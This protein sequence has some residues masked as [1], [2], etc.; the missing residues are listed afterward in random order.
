MRKRFLPLLALVALA[1]CT[2]NDMDLKESND[3]VPIMAGANALSVD[4]STVTRAPFEETIGADNNLT[5]MVLTSKTS[6]SYVQTYAKGCM[7]FADETT[8]VGYITDN[9]TT[10]P[11]AVAFSGDSYYP[12]NGDKL[13]FSALYP[14]DTKWSV[15][16]T[17]AS[18]T[19]D[20][21]TDVMA[22]AEVSGDKTAH[23]ATVA[24]DPVT[25]S[26]I[27]A[28]TFNHVLTKLNL[29][30]KAEDEVAIAAWGD[31]SKIEL[32]KAGNT[33]V[34]TKVTVTLLD[35]SA[36]TASAFSTGA[37]TFK[38]YGL[39][40]VDATLPA[41]GK[42]KTYTDTE[43]AAQTYKLTTT[44]TYQAYTL[45]APIVA[46]GDADYTFKIYASKAKDEFA[47][48]PVD[49]KKSGTAYTGDTQGKAFDITLL[50][51]AATI[52]ATAA[53]T[54]WNVDDIDNDDTVIE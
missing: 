15:A 14:A 6:N 29:R 4:A 35:G 19:F 9:A 11:P 37:P 53:V 51:K 16:V 54:G 45:A 10:P 20:G 1:S 13:Y 27:P 30:F 23:A 47:V 26:T 46:D 2:Q 49:L 32:I 24:P 21:C 44:S 38:C 5:A 50:F 8:A 36:V 41:T 12:A 28:F 22:A 7:T 43:Y 3:R 48:V 34:N 39:T 40:E 18:Y 52:T 33:T 25:P 17:D 42:I 31:I